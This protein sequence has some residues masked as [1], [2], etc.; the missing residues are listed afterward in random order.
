MVRI[1]SL[2]PGDGFYIPSL[3]LGGELMGIGVGSVSVRYDRRTQVDI[4]ED[5]SF[6][7]RESELRI[8]RGTMVTS[9]EELV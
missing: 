4:G 6:S 7:R 1:D 3:G 9:L 2:K 8:S 5:V